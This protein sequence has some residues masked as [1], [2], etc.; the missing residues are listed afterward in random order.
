MSSPNTSSAP[1]QV[2]VA[3]QGHRKG[4]EPGIIGVWNNRDEA[5]AE[6]S[7]KHNYNEE[8]SNP[9]HGFWGTT[10]WSIWLEGCKVK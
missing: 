9:E 7:E 10:E 8:F 6:I 2:F 4:D 3:I 1:S 5:I